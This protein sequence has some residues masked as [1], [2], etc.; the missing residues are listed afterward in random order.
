M[1]AAAG[2]AG[3]LARCA[4]SSSWVGVGG[5]SPPG[6]DG[7]RLA[8]ETACGLTAEEV[9]MVIVASEVAAAVAAKL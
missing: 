6:E 8:G 4:M 2:W 5:S 3:L 1:T 9:V 7:T